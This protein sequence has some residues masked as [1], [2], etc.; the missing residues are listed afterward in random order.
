[1]EDIH[2]LLLC[3]DPSRRLDRSYSDAQPLGHGG[4]GQVFRM[5]HRMS[6]EIRAIKVI[7]KPSGVEELQAVP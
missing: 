5:T 6:K 3:P 2:S 4:F 1:M 7:K